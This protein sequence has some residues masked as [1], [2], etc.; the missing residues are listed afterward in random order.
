MSKFINLLDMLPELAQKAKKSNTKPEE[1]NTM[2]DKIISKFKELSSGE[3]L[4]VGTIIPIY[5]SWTIYIMIG[6]PILMP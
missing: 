1:R 2:K 6:V 4:Y 3:R 5:I